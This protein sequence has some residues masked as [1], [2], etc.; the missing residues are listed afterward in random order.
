MDILMRLKNVPLFASLDPPHLERIAAIADRCC[1]PQGSL[2]FREGEVGY[3]FFIIDS[4]QVSLQ[5]A[6]LPATRE[7]LNLAG[8]GE[9]LGEEALLL[10]DRH[11]QSA[12]AATDVEVISIAKS[13]FDRLVGQQPQI[14]IQLQPSRL[15]LERLQAPTFPWQDE[16]ELTLLL[17]RRHWVAFAHDLPIPLLMLLGLGV[18]AW[19]LRQVGLL[20]SLPGVLLFVSILPAT[21]T[22]W[23]YLDWQND[24][25]L[26]TSKRIL[27]EE[28][29]ILLY[30]TWDEAPLNKVT[31]TTVYRSFPG[32]MLGYGTLHIQTASLRGS[33]VLDYL[34]DPEQVQQVICEYAARLGAARGQDTRQDIRSELSRQIGRT[35]FGQK[36]AL[37][38]APQQ[39]EE[40]RR[41]PS[42]LTRLL[43]LRSKEGNQVI[44]RQHW[45]FLIRQ[46]AAPAILF[47][48]A[49][50][51]IVVTLLN[52]SASFPF[53]LFLVSLVLWLG[54]LIWLWW[55]VVDW[56][57]DIYVVTDQLI[58]DIKKKPLFV[59]ERRRQ[60][61]LDMI[62][63]VFLRKEGLL[64][65]LLN[66]GDVVIQTAGLAGEFTFAGVSDPM[67]VQR[68]IFRRVDHYQAQQQHRD[69]Q[70]DRSELSEWFRVY[71][72]L[73]ESHDSAVS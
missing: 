43:R 27:H 1:L 67:R 3:T 38:P 68:E 8:E 70:R 41:R 24:F 7:G 28:K 72:E 2:L 46:S 35:Q 32:S 61:T 48:L 12:Q 53:S 19:L 15:V 39:A 29:V 60:A 30:Q 5:K 37:P 50:V 11:G 17:R 56:G 63:N 40:Q 25:Y 66:Y 4:G 69:S 10:G 57:N 44:W 55:R 59:S 23:L 73:Q 6:G 64:T 9:S 54:S 36:Q 52:V 22:L 71:H 21:V 65:A 31:N 47:L 34:P 33:M 26:V 58:I 20:T 14:R 13:A 51:L 18:A 42:Q 62:Q 49:T 45:V 16:D